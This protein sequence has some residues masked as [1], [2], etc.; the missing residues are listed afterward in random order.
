MITTFCIP[1]EVKHLTPKYE[2]GVTNL[3]DSMA[4][5]VKL[6][7]AILDLLAQIR[8]EAADAAYRRGYEQG[9]TDTLDKMT[10]AVTKLY[11]PHAIGK[12]PIADSTPLDAL[13]L[14]V[15]S[16]RRLY[17]A[18][19]R[20]I[21]DLRAMSESDIGDLHQV[22]PRIL[23]DIKDRCREVGIQLRQP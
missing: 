15:T 5:E 13:G 17:H 22:G 8:Q 2:V 21:G 9:C 1:C 16:Y 4:D 18:G 3:G 20:T 14:S 23:A 6:D 11:P 19:I 10:D 12:E 7:R